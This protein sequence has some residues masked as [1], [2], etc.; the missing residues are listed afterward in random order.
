MELTLSPLLKGTVKNLLGSA[1]FVVYT[2]DKNSLKSSD[3][4]LVINTAMLS[5]NLPEIIHSF[6]TDGLWGDNQALTVFPIIRQG[7]WSFAT[8]SA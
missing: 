1:I 2:A 4:G 7:L 6:R 3:R 8:H 5:K